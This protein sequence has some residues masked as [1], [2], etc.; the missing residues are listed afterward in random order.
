MTAGVLVTG[1]GGMLGRA[2]VAALAA[3]GHE[4]AAAYHRAPPPHAAPAARW[5]PLE[6]LATGAGAE[7]AAAAPAAI[8]HCAAAIPPRDAGREAV[9]A[10]EANRTMDGAVIAACEEA[11]ARL[12]YLSG[13]S[14]YGL[15][16]ERFDE[17][18]PLAP[19]GPYVESKV[20]AEERIAAELSDYSV[21]RVSAP[22]GPGQPTRTV[23]S[24]F[25]DLALA[26][27]PLRYHGTGARC[28]DFIAAEDVAGAIVAAVSGSGPA[29][30]N[31]ASGAPVS[32]AEL[33]RAVVA[34]VGST[35]DVGPSG[36]P[37]PQEHH[38][39]RYDVSRIAAELGWRPR[40]PLRRGLHRYV[41]DRRAEGSVPAGD[42]AAPRPTPT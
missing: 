9:Q 31:V 23:L 30:Y 18:S 39:A 37:D 7:L 13:T 8:V 40:V 4:V 15:G 24:L 41:E 20:A 42:G 26:S 34:A 17:D 32:M 29:V 33:A 1:A 10:R 36:R 28:Q 5:F 22:Y 2:A 35:S 16:D 38:R 19:G 25:T 14:V 6:L 3:A 27:Q 21:L 11:G 12:V